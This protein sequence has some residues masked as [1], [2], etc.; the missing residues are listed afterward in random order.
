MTGACK[1]ALAGGIAYG[2]GMLTNLPT[3]QNATYPI[4]YP[5]R[6]YPD[7]THSTSD[8]LPVP[9]WK[10]TL[11][12]TNHREPINPRPRQHGHIA[13]SQKHFA[14]GA[15]TYNEGCQDDVNKHVW[16]A[17]MWGADG[18]GDNLP[19]AESDAV[20][21][22]WL[23]EYCKLHFGP[24]L[25]ALTMEG[26]YS[27]ERNWIVQGDA[28]EA[29]VN[30]TLSIFRAV[31][32][33]MSVRDRWKWRLQQLLYRANFDAFATRRAKAERAGEEKAVAHLREALTASG[34][35]LKHSV[36]MAEGILDAAAAEADRDSMDLWVELR[37]WAEGAPRSLTP[38]RRDWRG[39]LCTCTLA[40]AL[41]HMHSCTSTL[42]HACTSTCLHKHLPAQ[43]LACTST[44]LHKHSS[45]CTRAHVYWGR[46]ISSC[47][48]THAA[49]PPE[50]IASSPTPVRICPF[51]CVLRA[52]VCVCVFAPPPLCSALPIHSPAV[53]SP[54]LRLGV[55]QARCY[56]R[57]G[58]APPE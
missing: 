15:V 38:A 1:I 35:D 7:I 31:E 55:Y 12:V 33:S 2:P 47:T 23:F 8:Q 28:Y 30:S 36:A 19:V 21:R 53:F 41:M 13:A 43:A 6:L 40:H 11:S 17:V 42:A 37:V 57:Y 26:I 10:P 20:V 5:I 49:S 16:L 39:S 46:G 58:S 45:T 9:N 24:S 3:F 54:A 56:T 18:G 48:C 27:L 51:V 32:R 50:H 44:C 4:N 25:A 29:Q 14:D 34:F 52:C 22:R